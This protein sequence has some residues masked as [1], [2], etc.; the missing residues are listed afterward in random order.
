MMD[1]DNKLSFSYVMNQMKM[2]TTGDNRTARLI[3]ALYAGLSK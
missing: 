3:M 2:T 1:L